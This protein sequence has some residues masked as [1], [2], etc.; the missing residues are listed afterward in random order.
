MATGPFL[1]RQYIDSGWDWA[2]SSHTFSAP[3][4]FA[5]VGAV[6]RALVRVANTFRTSGGPY[7]SPADVGNDVFGI[8]AYFTGTGAIEVKQQRS[9]ATYLGFGLEI[10]EFI[11]EVGG[12]SGFI[13]R[14][15]GEATGD[16]TGLTGIVDP[17]RCIPFLTGVRS[18]LTGA[19]AQEM[20][21]YLTLDADGAAL[22]WHRG[23]G[24]SGTTTY[25]YAIVEFL[26]R[27][28]DIASVV[29]TVLSGSS[30]SITVPDVGDWARAF[31]EPQWAA[32]NSAANTQISARIGKSASTIAVDWAA[33]AS[34]SGAALGVHIAR[35]P[36]INVQHGTISKTSPAASYFTQSITSLPSI[37]RSGLI[38]TAA[39]NDS[40]SGYVKHAKQTLTN[41]TTQL[42]FWSSQG[43]GQLDVAYQ[44]IDFGQETTPIIVATPPAVAATGAVAAP[45]VEI[46]GAVVATPAAAS[47]LGAVAG[48]SVVITGAP[49][50]TPSPAIAWG[51]V[52]LPLV[53]IETV[54]LAT[55]AAELA[56]EHC[57]SAWLVLVTLDHPDLDAPLRF[58]S[59]AV[60]TVSQGYVFAPMAFAI[61]LP[62]DVEA[63]APRAQP[64]IDNTSQEIIA[65]LRG[66]VEP[67]AVTLQ[68]VRAG[69]PDVIEREWAGLEWRASSYDL[70]FVSGGLGVED[71][72]AEEFPY[73]T[74]DG[75]FAGLWP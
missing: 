71:M 43:G 24:G 61:T 12:G 49:L 52:G 57:A 32:P 38:A 34:V 17:S 64:R 62:D 8:T 9:T 1:K 68:I 41:S 75:R 30:G 42:G 29:A 53:E 46:T 28:W 54:A 55:A 11:G 22:R 31:I 6:N 65:S 67:L 51:E 37:A 58:T 39:N 36:L 45:S 4:D 3:G 13:V 60:Q 23:G 63:R 50:A 56:A 33:G 20:T 2:S 40:G 48:P 25:S 69:D 21:G 5:A 19:A 47:A 15:Q 26:G 18:S 35:N 16:V 72:A 44:A 70:A 7:N 59:D 74:F 73:E 10:W 27:A 66:L 14:A